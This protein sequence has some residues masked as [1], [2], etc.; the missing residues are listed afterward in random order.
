MEHTHHPESF[1]FVWGQQ[2]NTNTRKRSEICPKSTK[3][4]NVVDDIYQAVFICTYI[5]ISL[6]IVS[7][8]SI[9]HNRL[10]VIV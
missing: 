10:I 5:F 3:N 6:F 2:L 1:F 9:E 7:C 8:H 4:Q